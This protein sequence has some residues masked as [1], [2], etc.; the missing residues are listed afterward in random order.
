MPRTAESAHIEEYTMP[1]AEAQM[2]ATLAL[3]TGHVQACCSAHRAAMAEKIVANLAT[4]AENP[5]LSPG[6]KTLLKAL[7]QRWQS[8]GQA[9]AQRPVAERSMWHSSPSQ[10]Q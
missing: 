1:C 5:R 9:W 4:M 7:G 2:A 8:Q 10:V 3:M 6:F